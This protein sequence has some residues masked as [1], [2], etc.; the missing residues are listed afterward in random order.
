MFLYVIEKN[1]SELIKMNKRT[2]LQATNSIDQGKNLPIVKIVNFR[3]R[4]RIGILF[5]TLLFTE[6]TSQRRQLLCY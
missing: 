3:F 6:Q 4:F 1:S 2:G 5:L